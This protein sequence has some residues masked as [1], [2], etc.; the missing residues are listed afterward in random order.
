MV[1]TLTLP[2]GFTTTVVLWNLIKDKIGGRKTIIVHVIIGAADRLVAYQHACSCQGAW[3][4]GSYIQSLGSHRQLLE[5]CLKVLGAHR[6]HI[7]IVSTKKYIGA[8]GSAW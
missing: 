4:I 1:A 8:L 5:S 2:H 7:E 6:E 3:H